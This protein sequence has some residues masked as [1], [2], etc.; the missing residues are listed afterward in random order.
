ML[1]FSDY[2]MLCFSGNKM[3]CLSGYQMLCYSDSIECFI[4]VH[5]QMLCFLLYEMLCFNYSYQMLCFNYSHQL[6]CFNYFIKCFVLVTLC[7]TCVTPTWVVTRNTSSL[8]TSR[9]L[10]LVERNQVQS[11]TKH[12]KIWGTF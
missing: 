11:Q 12:N 8:W 4:F 6:L 5:Y 3:L 10:S 2:Q 9:S 7:T 1:C